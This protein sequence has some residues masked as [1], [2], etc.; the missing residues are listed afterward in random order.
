MVEK[1]SQDERGE[2]IALTR[3]QA[4]GVWSSGQ[5]RRWRLGSPCSGLFAG[6]K[7]M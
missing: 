7:R 5:T 2:E 3:S 6:F 4:P 1:K